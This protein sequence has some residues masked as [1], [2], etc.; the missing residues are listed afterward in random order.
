MV[1]NFHISAHFYAVKLWGQLYT[2]LLQIGMTKLIKV[3]S[4]NT[5][6]QRHEGTHTRTDAIFEDISDDMFL[7]GFKVNGNEGI[8][9]GECRP[10]LNAPRGA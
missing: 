9:A 7:R 2:T 5:L 1:C 10:R 8:S 4:K 6:K 3:L